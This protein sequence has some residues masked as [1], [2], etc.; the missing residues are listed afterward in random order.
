MHY[1]VCMKGA[2]ILQFGSSKKEPKEHQPGG[3]DM[4]HTSHK[5]DWTGPARRYSGAMLLLAIASLLIACGSGGAE[6]TNVAAASNAY[7]ATASFAWDAVTAPNL[8]GYRIYYGTAPGT[9]LQP[10]GQGLSVENVTTYT[11]KGLSNGTRYY[12]AVTAFDTI[13]N[14]SGYSNEVFKDTL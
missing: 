7:T 10:F 12:F 2:S 14:E 13:G 8:G 6:P 1:D 3:N 4:L 9:Y 5:G 11:Q